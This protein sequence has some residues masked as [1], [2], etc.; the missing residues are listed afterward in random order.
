MLKLET[1]NLDT[2]RLDPN[3]ITGFIDAEGCFTTSIYR[4]SIDRNLKWTVK[5]SFMVELH[6]RDLHL[7][8]EI[9]SYFNHAG[10]ITLR[11]NR[12][13]ANYQIR[14]LRSILGVVL[15][16]FDKYPLISQK[17]NDYLYFKEI[18]KLIE[19]GAHLTEKGLLKIIN[20]KASLNNGLS[21]QLQL[22]FPG[23]KTIPRTKVML[24]D[25]INYSWLAGFC[26]GDGCFYVNIPK[27]PSCI[28]G[29][30]VKLRLSLTQH[31]RD[32]KLLTKIAE[33]LNCGVIYRHG[34]DSVVLRVETFKDI[35]NTIIPIFEEYPI[36]GIRSLDFKD[37][38]SISL[39]VQDKLHLTLSG[40]A[41]IWH[42]K[43]GMNK[44]R[45]SN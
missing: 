36:R 5:P 14:D 37:F 30:S 2:P 23:V 17:Y 41:E 19:N 12:D 20:L 1:Q 16:H 40:L 7:L 45:K 25:K 39:M 15:P 26:S 4:N 18:I 8:S 38:C 33:T 27:T 10:T 6:V 13:S 43:S 9:K 44:G 28:L 32:K 21:D 3:W 34:K 24:P 22:S 42:I 31:I 11:S 35:S 29:Y